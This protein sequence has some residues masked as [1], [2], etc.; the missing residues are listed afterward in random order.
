MST[1]PE[2]RD[3]RGALWRKWDLHFHTPT[4]FDY[5]A[6]TVTNQQIVDQLI[7]N[8]VGVVAVTDHHCIDPDRITELRQIANGR[9]VF[10]PGIE[11]RC[12]LGGTTT[13]HYIGVFSDENDVHELWTELSG[14]LELTPTKIRQTGDD[15]VWVG[16]EKGM[17]VIHDLGGFVTIHAGDRSNSLEKIKNKP[18]F[19]QKV[20]TDILREYVD[21]LEVSDIDDCAG[22]INTVFP[23]I[24]FQRPIIVGSDNHDI[25]NYSPICPCWIRGDASFETLKHL[26]CEPED[27]VFLGDTPLS[28]DRVLRN[29]TKY[30]R[31][32]DVRK[33]T[34]ASL[35]ET[36]FDNHVPLNHGLVAIIGNK[37]SGKSALA[38]IIGLLGDSQAGDAF[39][40]LTSKKFCKPSNN[41]SQAFQA[42][43][44]WESG[45]TNQRNL[46]DKVDAEIESIRYLPQEYIESVCN[47]LQEHGS[48]KFSQELASVIFSHV[49]INDRLGCQTFDELLQYKTS[50]KQKAITVKRSELRSLIDRVVVLE[51][52]SSVANLKAI[53]EQIVAKKRE[54]EAHKLSK[55]KVVPKPEED[56]AA[57]A[58]TET[59]VKKLE[60]LEKRKAALIAKISLS[61]D[62]IGVAKRRLAASDRLATRLTSLTAEV[63][64]A[65]E[66]STKDCSDIGLTFQELVKFSV[67][68]TKLELARSEANLAVANQN[69][70]LAPET[71]A[72]PSDELKQIEKEMQAVR[73]EL[74]A[75]SQKYQQYLV[76]KKDWEAQ[77]SAIIG[78][79][80]KE[81]T[82]KFFEALL[83]ACKEAE[84][85]IPESIEKILAKSVEVYSGLQELAEVYSELYAP[86]Q[87]FIEQ[88]P[89]AKSQFQMSF[90]TKLVESEFAEG[91]L[92][93]IAQNRKGSFC[94]ATEGR[95]RVLASLAKTD[96]NDPAIVNE[97]LKE[98]WN[99]LH[100]DLRIEDN[101]VVQ[102]SD[103]LAKRSSANDLYRFIFELAFLRPFFTLKWGGKNVE[104]LSP[105]ERGTLLLVFYLLIDRSDIPLI[106]DQPEENLDNQTVYDV[107]V[108]SIKEARRRRQLI[109]V[110]HNP[111]LAV[112]CDADQ[113]IC[114]SV[115]KENKN[116][117]TYESGTIENPEINKKILDIL[118][119]TR[120]AFENRDSKYHVNGN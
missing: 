26:R 109:V 93:Q 2:K 92:S 81:D 76:D 33:A 41:K 96:F 50:E 46:S 54:L 60:E 78:D 80:T 64:L 68:R 86:V 74:A 106:I 4:S 118:E 89:L 57:R 22:Y 63:N 5:R 8:E 66:Q 71:A 18:V 31:S 20:K 62:A 117:V 73:N 37:G 6:K 98:I 23:E 59:A 14:K 104:Q 38:D 69:A 1:I 19:K 65:E 12:E 11:L 119:G 70:I 16:Y 7:A 36:W 87:R 45:G 84:K 34:G 52:Q 72:V 85:K 13:I 25:L 103:Q 95:E 61:N 107:L 44:E 116:K 88:H 30:V 100:V 40:F 10:L 27:R 29:R 115:D 21:F 35:S 102:V 67:D 39:S 75:P 15:K 9:V 90:E 17:K 120:P 97:F 82:I 113:V 3:A 77:H 47:E 32:I 111:N 108:P 83:A 42:T 51:K 105:G 28:V 49:E 99:A 112:V 114:A 79:A 101:P 24:G 53:T 55:P 110:T 94:G 43:I 91:F 48:G 56:E 58:A